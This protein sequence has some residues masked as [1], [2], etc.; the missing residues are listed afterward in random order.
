MTK[1]LTGN[2]KKHLL[3]LTLPS[4]AGTFAMMVFNHSRTSP[5]ASE[6]QPYSLSAFSAKQC[7]VGS[8][9]QKRHITLSCHAVS[10]EV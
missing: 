10:H 4:I 7:R 6:K 5:F 9:S 3:R 2:V 8:M 1:L